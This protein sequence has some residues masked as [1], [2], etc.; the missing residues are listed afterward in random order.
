MYLYI[1]FHKKY[2]TAFLKLI[3]LKIY[4]FLGSLKHRKIRTGK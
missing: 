4:E 1:P 2:E 3:Q